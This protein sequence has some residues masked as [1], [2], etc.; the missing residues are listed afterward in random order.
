MT[1]PRLSFPGSQDCDRA[2]DDD[3]EEGGR[4]RIHRHVQ[5]GRE[6]EADRLVVQG[7]SGDLGRG[8]RDLP[9]LDVGTGDFLFQLNFVQGVPSTRGPGL[10]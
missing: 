6:A 3:H 4:H 8:E 10:G 2:A 5:R 7:R 9:N 1:Q